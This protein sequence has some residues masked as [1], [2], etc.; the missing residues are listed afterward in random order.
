MNYDIFISIARQK[1]TNLNL[2]ITDIQVFVSLDG[3]KNDKF[4]VKKRQIIQM[5]STVFPNGKRS[6]DSNFA[7][8][9]S[10]DRPSSEVVTGMLE[11]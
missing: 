3:L 11:T 8:S 5:N 6:L 2:Q 9:K 10:Q 4:Q 1:T 7:M